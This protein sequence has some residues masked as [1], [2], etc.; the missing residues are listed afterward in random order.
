M[1]KILKSLTIIITAVLM[2]MTTACLSANAFATT[3]SAD[4]LETITVR[5][6]LDGECNVTYD[7][8]TRTFMAAIDDRVE[9]I[10]VEGVMKDPNSDRYIILTPEDAWQQSYTG[11]ETNGRVD[12]GYFDMEEIWDTVKTGETY[13]LKTVPSRLSL[14]SLTA[15][16]TDGDKNEE[17]SLSPEFD[18]YSPGNE[19]RTFTANVDKSMTAVVIKA[20][21]GDSYTYTVDGKNVQN[22]EETVVD[23][24]NE[25]TKTIN[26]ELSK[27]GV[28][29]TGH[30]ELAVTRE[31]FQPENP[32]DPEINPDEPKVQPDKPE[33][34]PTKAQKSNAA[35]IAAAK[36]MTVQK[37]KVKFEKKKATVTWKRTKGASGYQVQFKIKGAKQFRNLK[38]ATKK[39]SVKSKKLKKGKK[40]QFRVRTYKTIAGHKYYGKW[41]TV[42]TRKCK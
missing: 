30:Y 42:K 23:L 17:I 12:V 34:K 4:E 3:D 22:G 39:T 26:I 7:E 24:G 1:E 33:A 25:V 28:E 6:S 16:A 27:E 37:L 19:G 31:G 21:G 5:T 20:T 2:I 11:S 41:T 29:A 9:R 14:S 18:M 35:L 40:Y 15:I 10:E 13:T 36:K 32:D 38:K 8:A